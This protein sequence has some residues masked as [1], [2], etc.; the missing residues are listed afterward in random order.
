MHRA[1]QRVFLACIV[2]LLAACA[3][4]LVVVPEIRLL[5]P[6]LD[7]KPAAAN[8]SKVLFFNNSNKLLFGIDG[9]GRVGIWINGI[10]L[11]VLEIGEYAQ[12]SLPRG[13]HDIELVHVDVVTF[14][15]KHEIVVGDGPLFVEVFATIV[16]NDLKTFDALPTGNYLPKPFTPYRPN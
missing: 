2:A 6:E 7:A 10:G 4:P 8:E 11:G 15:S 12:V 14:N 1:L 9:T 5:P 13:R 3:G 16:S